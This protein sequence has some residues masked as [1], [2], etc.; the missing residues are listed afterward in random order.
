MRDRADAAPTVVRRDAGPVVSSQIEG[1]P[2]AGEPVDDHRIGLHDVV[3]M[4]GQQRNELLQAQVLAA[5]DREVGLVAE[6]RQFVPGI[7]R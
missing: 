4:L 6:S 1:A 5:G 2:Q 7:A 3:G